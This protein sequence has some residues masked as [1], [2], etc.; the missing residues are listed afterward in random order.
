MNVITVKASNHICLCE[1]S[2]IATLIKVNGTLYI[3]EYVGEGIYIVA[4][5]LSVVAGCRF[6]ICRVAPLPA[7]S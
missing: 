5:M 4:Y 3:L 6:D 2:L 1:K 7:V